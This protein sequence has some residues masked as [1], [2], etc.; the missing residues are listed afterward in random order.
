MFK[1]NSLNGIISQIVETDYVEI[2][3]KLTCSSQLKSFILRLLNKDP[4]ARPSATDALN[5]P[6]FRSDH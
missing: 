2:I 4:N 1:G 6:W 3:D 5:D